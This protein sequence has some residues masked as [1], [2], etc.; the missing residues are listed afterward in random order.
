MDLCGLTISTLLVVC[1]SSS[2]HGSTSSSAVI[3]LVPVLNSTDSRVVH[4]SEVKYRY[5]ESTGGI[6]VSI[7][8]VE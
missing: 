6:E 1:M 5:I 7:S 3:R 4:N 2:L 8:I